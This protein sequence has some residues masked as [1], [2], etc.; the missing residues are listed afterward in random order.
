VESGKATVAG[1]LKDTTTLET[2][3]IN[4]RIEEAR[5]AIRK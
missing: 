5:F 4:S 3:Q 2:I 1:Q